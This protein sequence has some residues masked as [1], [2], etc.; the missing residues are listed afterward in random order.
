MIRT[1]PGLFAYARRLGTQE[2]F[3]VFNTSTSTQTLTNRPTIFPAGTQIVNLFDTNEV[4]TVTATPET[5]PITVPGTSRED[6]RGPIGLEA[7]R[8][9]G[10]QQLP[11]PRRRQRADLLAH[12]AAVQQADGHRTAWKPTSAT[13]PPVSGMFA[14]SPARRHAD[15]HR[16]RRRP[17]GPDD[18]DRAVDQHGAW[19]PFRAMRCFRRYEMRL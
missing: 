6:L 1:A 11:G 12:R 8:P 5:P 9:G 18:D 4:L 17:S 16:G 13:I 7:A 15:L 19:M 3:V 10:H 14:W 2:V